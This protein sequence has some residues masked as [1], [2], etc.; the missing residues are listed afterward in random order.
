LMVG[1]CLTGRR[2]LVRQPRRRHPGSQVV[3]QS[4]VYWLSVRRT[5][6]CQDGR[7]VPQGWREAPSPGWW[8]PADHRCHRSIRWSRPSRQGPGCPSRPHRSP[9]APACSSSP[10]VG[11]PLR[12]F[13]SRGGSSS[14]ACHSRAR[15]D[16]QPRYLADTHGQS[17]WPHNLA[18][19]RSTSKNASREYA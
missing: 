14:P 6:A 18:V 9:A 12:P 3:T 5:I 11:Q 1:W 16:G 15:S 4:I 17:R 2:A 7:A 10:A 13:A 8:S 19:P